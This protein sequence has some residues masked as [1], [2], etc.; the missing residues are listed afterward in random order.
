[1][2]ATKDRSHEARPG[3]PLPVDPTE[4]SAT[5]SMRALMIG[6]EEGW[7]NFYCPVNITEPDEVASVLDMLSRLPDARPIQLPTEPGIYYFVSIK[8]RDGSLNVFLHPE[9]RV[10]SWVLGVASTISREAAD[11]VQYLTG[12]IPA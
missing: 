4:P 7:F 5:Q 3:F 1:M 6:H 11:K 2:S 8:A 10:T 9:G 12:I